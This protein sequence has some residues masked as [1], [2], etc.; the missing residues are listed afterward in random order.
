MVVWK[1]VFKKKTE[2]SEVFSAKINVVCSYLQ[3]PN[4]ELLFHSST[5][6]SRRQKSWEKNPGEKGLDIKNSKHSFYII[7]ITV[8][9]FTLTH[10]THHKLS[11]FKSK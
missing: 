4:L 7:L 11:Q 9:L 10:F 3:A 5:S 8:G 6:Q 2:P 1:L